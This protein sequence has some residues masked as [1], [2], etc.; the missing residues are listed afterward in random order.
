M[1]DNR[2]QWARKI[3]F[4]FG[5][6]IDLPSNLEMWNHNQLNNKFSVIGVSNRGAGPILWPGEYNY[7]LEDRIKRAD[8]Y[9]REK[10]DIEK[11]KTIKKEDKKRLITKVRNEIDVS[12]LDIYRFWNSAIYGEDMIQQ[13]LTHFW[14]NHFTVGGSG[15]RNFVLGDFIYRVIHGNLK[16]SFDQLLY[17]VT[18]HIGMLDYLD[19]A[20]SVGEKSKAFYFAQKRGK[21]VGLN[22]NLGRELLELHTVSLARG[23]TEKDIRGTAKVLAGW[24][25]NADA[26]IRKYKQERK[27]KPGWPVSLADFIAKPYFRDRAEPG[28]KNVLGQKF[29]AGSKAL[30][31]LTDM[32]ASDDHTARYLSKKLALHFI[33]E[34]AT[35][36]EIKIIYG[37]W[38]KS[39]GDLNKVHKATLEVI[40][41]TRSKKFL[42]P[43]TWMF[44]AIRISGADM[45]PGF[46][47]EFAKKSDLSNEPRE[48]LKELGNSFWTQRQPDGYSEIKENWISTEHLDRRIKMASKIFSA[49]PKRSGEEIAEILDFSDKSKRSI[50]MAPDERAKFIIALCSAD[51]M[52]V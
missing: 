32:L 4:G 39:K 45:M 47:T 44:Q 16:S 3:G 41:N 7:S 14:T 29:P 1:Y 20:D 21:T 50:K 8:V 5:P 26:V 51:F 17:E 49:K 11:S 10:D 27:N 22:D 40:K 42:W 30:R 46:S 52:E 36:E 18:T 31:K 24:G 34:G 48:I 6:E 13:R 35:D 38:K 15:R 2:H 23:Y 37:A 33:G 25:V 12:K 9:T 19:N 28:Y 43:T